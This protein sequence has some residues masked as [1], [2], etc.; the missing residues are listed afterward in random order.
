VTAAHCIRPRDRPTDLRVVMGSSKR[1]RYFYY[2]FQ[3][4]PKKIC[5]LGPYTVQKE[6]IS[7]SDRFFVKEIRRVI[8]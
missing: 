4:T 5:P 3:V 1:A 2:F 7:N 8:E 6:L